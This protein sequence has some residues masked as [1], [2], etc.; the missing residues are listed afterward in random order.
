MPRFS[1]SCRA[2]FHRARSLRGMPCVV[3]GKRKR[4]E[5]CRPHARVSRM[6]VWA[7]GGGWCG[8]E[9]VLQLRSP[10]L[11]RDYMSSRRSTR[12]K[13]HVRLGPAWA[14]EGWGCRMRSLSIKGATRLSADLV[15]GTLDW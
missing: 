4:N 7:A 10:F 13:M 6:G 12:L 3:R 14:G 15:T 5:S 2:L 9:D 11:M 8:S 1:M